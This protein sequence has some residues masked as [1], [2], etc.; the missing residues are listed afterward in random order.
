MKTTTEKRLD[1]IE[2][3]IENIE[4]KLWCDGEFFD[5]L[6]T[7]YETH[8]INEQVATAKVVDHLVSNGMVA[9]EVAAA[10]NHRITKAHAEAE[11][12]SRVHE[13][14]DGGT[15]QMR[16][17]AQ[18]DAVTALK[19]LVKRPRAAPSGLRTPAAKR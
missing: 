13:V 10:V 14:D 12:A 18:R 8:A 3:D 16:L 2:T 6:A 5:S 7:A 17:A 4:A 9:P 19:R 11:K 1:K 15:A